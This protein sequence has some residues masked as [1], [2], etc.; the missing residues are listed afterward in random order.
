MPEIVPLAVLVLAALAELI[1]V[2]AAGF[3]LW[4]A[5]SS[6]YNVSN[7]VSGWPVV[8]GGLS[9]AIHWIGD[10]FMGWVNWAN[11]QIEW[12]KQ[13]VGGWYAWFETSA[14]NL[15]FGP[16]ANS[17]SALWDWNWHQENWLTN[18]QGWMNNWAQP[19]IQAL[20]GWMTGWVQPSINNLWAWIN[21]LNGFIT[22]WIVPSINNEWAWIFSQQAWLQGIQGWMNNWAQPNIANLWAWQQWLYQ[23]DLDED[24]AIA[25]RATLQQLQA[26]Q[27]RVQVLESII[28]SWAPLAIVADGGQDVTNQLRRIGTDPCK[29]CPEIDLSDLEGRVSALEVD[30][31]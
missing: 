28:S 27:V 17:I 4:A 13:V 2:V 5:A 9:G 20:W 7:W 22:G 12:Q 3:I 21:S 29:V 8:G 15:N 16:W 1:I 31:A 18:I 11:G 14:F 23:H 6:V 24:E 25:Q 30:A 19:N 26:L 10:Q